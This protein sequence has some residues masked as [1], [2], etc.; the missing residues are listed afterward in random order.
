VSDL[1]AAAPVSAQADHRRPGVLARLVGPVAIRDFRL[2]WLGEGISLLGDQFHYVALSWLVLQLTGSGLA[3]GTVLLAASIP[4]AVLMVLGGAVTDLVSPRTVAIL[5]NAARAAFVALLTWLVASESVQL[6]HLLVLGLL[7]GIVDAFFWPAVNA[8]IPMLVPA[9]R[10]QPAN[11]LHQAT[12]QLMGMLGPAAAGLVIA[13]VGTAPAFGFD[14]TTFAVAA[15]AG[16]AIR[17]GRRPPR[18]RS[19]EPTRDP[20]GRR[21][22]MLD[23]IRA[24]AAYTF[25]Q[26][27]LRAVL[28]V[29]LTL[30]VALNGPVSVGLP[31]L[32]ANRFSGGPATLGYLFAAWGGGALLGALAAGTLPEP[33]RLGLAVAVVAGSIGPVFAGVGLAP[34]VLPAVGLMIGLGLAIGWLNVVAITWIQRSVDPAM[35]GRVM[36]LVMLGSVGLT[37]LSYA[38]A[39]AI[40]DT[41]ATAMFVAAGAVILG[42]TAVVHASGALR[43]VDRA[44]DVG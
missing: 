31:W 30:N 7:F 21:D 34:A 28:V 12:M 19:T 17:G 6:W 23:L 26:P 13:W 41:W 11:A 8:L 4:R 18:S 5:S 36:S 32:A 43:A 14:A 27:T 10:L 33:R 40:V 20:V 39:G 35:L 9:E 44:P 15:V 24:G 29:S 2:L 38:V 16:L 42:A 1:P 3:L 37:P 25:R 22:G